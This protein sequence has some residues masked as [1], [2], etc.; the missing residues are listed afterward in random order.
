MKN[1]IAPTRNVLLCSEAL[2][3]LVTLA[4]WEDSGRGRFVVIDGPAGTG[5]TTIA[6][7][8]AEKFNGIFYRVPELATPRS[9]FSDLVSAVNHFTV[10][11]HSAQRLF[12]R[13]IAD[14][15]ARGWPPIFLDE[16]DRLD[17]VRGGVSLLE[18]ARDV[19]D[20]SGCPILLFSI[21]NLARRL[22]NPAGG[23]AE[24]FSS[25]VAARIRFERASQEDAELLAQSLLED[26]KLDAD[27][28]AHCVAASGGSFRPLLALYAEIERLARAA[29]IDKVGLAKYQQLASFAGLPAAAPARRAKSNGAEP[30][31]PKKAVA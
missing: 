15:A 29:G 12:E 2:T 1:K 11:L 23:Y 4:R 18:C 8:L 3:P 6:K 25:R 5:K 7:Y 30:E 10:G 13:L 27:L 9:F 31:R 24:A 17:R 28:I 16:S 21:A 22:A 19:H 20:S 26:V 14:L